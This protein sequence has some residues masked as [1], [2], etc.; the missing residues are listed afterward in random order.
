MPP[1]DG[2]SSAFTPAH[3]PRGQPAPA[4]GTCS[5]TSFHSNVAENVRRLF[6]GAGVDPQR[7]FLH[8]QLVLSV[9]CRPFDQ[10]ARRVTAQI[11][12]QPEGAAP[13]PFERALNPDRRMTKDRL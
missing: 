12:R 7:A 2:S 6:T 5:T 4:P 9:R 10:H 13:A 3:R 11:R 8:G 1:S